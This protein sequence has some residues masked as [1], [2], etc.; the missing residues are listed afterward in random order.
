MRVGRDCDVEAICCVAGIDWRADEICVCVC[1]CVCMCACVCVCM[2]ECACVCKY[3]R[4]NSLLLLPE[5]FY[6]NLTP[7]LHREYSRE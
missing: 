7:V 1:V 3:V 4:K 2:C 6:S 5:S